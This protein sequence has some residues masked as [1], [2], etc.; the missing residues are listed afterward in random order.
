[1]VTCTELLG[2]DGVRIVAD[3]I[4][5]CTRVSQLLVVRG[6]EDSKNIA[7]FPQWT[8]TV[9]HILFFFLDRTCQCDIAGAI[10]RCH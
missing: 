1:M 2:R 9:C 8:P 5:C 7:F 4:P 10:H 6:L 3:R